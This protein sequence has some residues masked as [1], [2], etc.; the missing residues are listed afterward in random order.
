VGNACLT[1]PTAKTVDAS[2]TLQRMCRRREK[3]APSAT[4]TTFDLALQRMAPS[5]GPLLIWILCHAMI[6]ACQFL[7][8]R[9]SEH[10]ERPR[11]VLHVADEI[12]YPGARQFEVDEG[13][14]LAHGLLSV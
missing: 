1:H 3:L 9:P 4:S 10:L 6:S 5:V 8:V 7:S 13:V 14:E 2:D 11:R 12:V